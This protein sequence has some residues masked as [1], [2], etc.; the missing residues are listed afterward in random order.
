MADIS[1]LFFDLGRSGSFGLE[2]ENMSPAQWT[3]ALGNP[4]TSHRAPGYDVGTYCFHKYTATTNGF[5]QASDVAC[6]NLA[7]TTTGWNN[8]SATERAE[9][10][11]NME[12]CAQKQFV[13][14]MYVG[15][16]ACE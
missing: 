8:L 16:T 15:P 9:A 5:Y 11:R 10:T 12:R 6:Q 7:K 4:V 1:T 2:A 13:A 14:S 3:T